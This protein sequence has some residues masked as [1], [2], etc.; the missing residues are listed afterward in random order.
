MRSLKNQKRTPDFK[1]MVALEAIKGDLSVNQIAS[2]YNIHPKQVTDWRDQLFSEGASIFIPKTSFR[3]TK[4]DLEKEDLL[5]TIGQ[6][7]F[8]LDHL[9]KKKP[10]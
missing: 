5:Q 3:K 4:T 8:D 1:L 2:K 9:K 10:Q 6:L 7:S